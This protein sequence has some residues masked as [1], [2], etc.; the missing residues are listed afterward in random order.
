ME[1]ADAPVHGPHRD[2]LG[3]AGQ[4]R[5]ERGV[6]GVVRLVMPRGHEVPLA[7]PS[8]F[9]GPRRPTPPAVLWAGRGPNR[10]SNL[11]GW[12][13]GGGESRSRPPARPPWSPLARG[14]AGSARVSAPRR[15]HSLSGAGR[16][17]TGTLL[18]QK[19]PLPS[20]GL[21]TR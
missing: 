21:P 4:P 15:S 2:Q 10:W 12:R 13:C 19:T 1:P 9:P 16:P 11:L 18:P 17:R 6:G 20:P 8:S 5:Q 7:S 3:Y 14:V